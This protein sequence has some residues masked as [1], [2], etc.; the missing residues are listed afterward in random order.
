MKL[1]IIIDR[2]DVHA[3]T[4][5][6][7]MVTLVKAYMVC[8]SLNMASRGKSSKAKEFHKSPDSPGRE[9]G[10]NRSSTRQ[11]DYILLYIL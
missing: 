2:F 3:R 4:A 10:D 11:Y 1:R 8:E 5:T 6:T 9:F 7:T